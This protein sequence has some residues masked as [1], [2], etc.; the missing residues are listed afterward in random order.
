MNLNGMSNKGAKHM[1]PTEIERKFMIK[2]LPKEIE[3]IKIITQKHIFKDDICSIRVRKT[4]DVFNKKNN[5]YTYNK[6]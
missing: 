1:L 2:Y 6:S 5:I 4:E 3:N